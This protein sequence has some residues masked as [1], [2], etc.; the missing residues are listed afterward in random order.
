VA[1]LSFFDHPIILVILEY[2]S[3][4]HLQPELIMSSSADFAFSFVIRPSAIRMARMKAVPRARFYKPSPW[5]GQPCRP[6]PLYLR[7]PLPEPEP[8]HP[9]GGA[10]G[11]G[12]QVEELLLL[13][14]PILSTP[15]SIPLSIIRA[16][17]AALSFPLST[18]SVFTLSGISFSLGGSLHRELRRRA[19]SRRW[20]L[21]VTGEASLQTR[22]ES[23]MRIG[24]QCTWRKNAL[25]PSLSYRNASRGRIQMVQV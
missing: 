11:S 14:L 6:P 1:N 19:K 22:R 2:C 25:A 8:R 23:W 24:A 15:S 4:E 3:T 16:S 18:T 13:E 10:Q 20:F 12:K 5:R 21:Y 7:L 17:F 9:R